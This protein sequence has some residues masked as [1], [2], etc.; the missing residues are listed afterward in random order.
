MRNLINFLLKNSSWFVFIFLEIICFYFIFSTNS[1]Q[2][3][4]YFNSSNEITGR[5]Y[6][7]TGGVLSYFGLRTENEDLLRRNTE[8]QSQISELKEYIYKL[9]NDSMKTDAFLADSLGRKHLPQQYILAR[10]ESNSISQIYNFMIINKG[11]NDGVKT[12]MGVASQNG[13]VGVVRDV[14]SNYAVVQPVLNPNSRFS[15]KILN[16]TTAGTL[17]W[18]G[19]DSRYASLTEYP[20]YEKVE[21]GDTI[22]TSGFSDIFPEGIFVGIVEDFK[23]ESN[24]NFYALKVKL[25][26]DFGALKNVFLL[27]IKDDE[28]KE[29]EEKIKNAKK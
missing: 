16:S 2:R 8:L 28:R 24:D 10:V 3:S 9:E 14:T 12:D 5:V 23:S 27:N 1:F 18:D 20:K 13:I 17:V 11:T 25:S 4:V 6:A 15:C 29:L 22:V 26:T 19:G 21:V 7:I